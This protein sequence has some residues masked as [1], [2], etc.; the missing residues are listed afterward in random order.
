MESKKDVLRITIRSSMAFSA[1]MSAV[2]PLP[3]PVTLEHT[4]AYTEH[5]V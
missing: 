4:A 2:T 3:A 1:V 5:H